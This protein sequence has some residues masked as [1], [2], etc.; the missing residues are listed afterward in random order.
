MIIVRGFSRCTGIQIII[1][2]AESRSVQDVL[3]DTYMLMVSLW[4]D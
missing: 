3:L 1:I 2:P 4:F